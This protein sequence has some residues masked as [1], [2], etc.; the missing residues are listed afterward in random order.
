M[1][2]N[3][4]G[5]DRP[6]LGTA[7]PAF[8][9]KCGGELYRA[10][11]VLDEDESRALSDGWRGYAPHGARSAGLHDCSSGADHQHAELILYRSRERQQSRTQPETPTDP[12]TLP[13]FLWWR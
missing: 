10:V 13:G 7:A 8:T 9:F 3:M 12:A 4:A 2:E 6:S 11:E 1:A 5:T